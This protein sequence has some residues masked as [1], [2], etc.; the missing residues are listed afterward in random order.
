MILNH[1]YYLMRSFL[2]FLTLIGKNET[3]NCPSDGVSIKILFIN[4]KFIYQ[5]LMIL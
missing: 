1:R 2:G 5:I 4:L 3:F